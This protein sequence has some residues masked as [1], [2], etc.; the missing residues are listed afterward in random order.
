MRSFRNEPDDKKKGFWKR[1]KLWEEFPLSRVSRNISDLVAAG[2]R[3]LEFE[4]DMLYV[5]ALGGDSS[6]RQRELGRSLR[7][8]KRILAA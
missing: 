2:V 6:S 5:A 3:E 7:A 4:G 8:A 1:E